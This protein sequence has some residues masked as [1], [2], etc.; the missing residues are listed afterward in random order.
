MNFIAN[1]VGWFYNVLEINII[2][3]TKKS[4]AINAR[5]QRAA[6]ILFMLTLNQSKLP[7]IKVIFFLACLTAM[8]ISC[9]KDDVQVP[10]PKLASPEEL[11]EENKKLSG[12]WGYILGTI[13]FFN[14]PGIPSGDGYPLKGSAIFDEQSVLKFIDYNGNQ[15]QTSYT[16]SGVDDEFFVDI[17]DSDGSLRKCNVILLTADSLKLQNKLVGTDTSRKLIYTQTFVKAKLADVT[18]NIFRVSVSPFIAPG[19]IFNFRV[20]VNI[21][22]THQGEQEQ[23]VESKKDLTEPY[24]YAYSPTEGDQ[25]RIALSGPNE[26][27]NG[28]VATCLA[29]YKGVPYGNDW[30]SSGT[31]SALNKSWTIAN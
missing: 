26:Y 23:L 3:I 25:V 1:L 6:V 20:D 12:T 22:I 16:L 10:Q 29:T 17:K 30:L 4:H 31:S 19:Y 15:T 5:T 7:M 21:Y 24:S 11:A 28:P 13:D 9:K 18:G 27:G 2:I 14:F 8:M